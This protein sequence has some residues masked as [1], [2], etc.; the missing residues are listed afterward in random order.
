V[1]DT[2]EF[3]GIKLRLRFIR[4]CGNRR[5]RELRPAPAEAARAAP[6]RDYYAD[7]VRKL[8][9]AKAASGML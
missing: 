9:T 7:L 5:P 1:I 3:L 4:A 6:D 8:Q 2:A